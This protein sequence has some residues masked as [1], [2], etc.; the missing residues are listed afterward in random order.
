MKEMPNIV[1]ME[2]LHVEPSTDQDEAS[3]QRTVRT[4]DGVPA[5]IVL[6]YLDDGRMTAQMLKMR[7]LQS[8]HEYAEAAHHMG[9]WPW[10]VWWGFKEVRLRKK[11]M[12]TLQQMSALAFNQIAVI[13]A[14]GKEL[15]QVPILFV[16]RESGRFVPLAQE[17]EL[18]LILEAA[19]V[20]P[21]PLVTVLVPNM[22]VSE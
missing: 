11:L 3:G 8:Q 19:K 7:Y 10:K 15:D 1:Q 16:R 12:V 2:F 13:V 6:R 14:R 21:I 22:P 5:T 4:V 18:R 9:V 17:N 20:A